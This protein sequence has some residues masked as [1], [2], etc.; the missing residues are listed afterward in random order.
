LNLEASTCTRTLA[1][2]GLLTEIMM[3]IGMREDLTDEQLEAFI[4]QF[5][6]QRA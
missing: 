1:A 4:A 2:N 3:L 5:P 6:I